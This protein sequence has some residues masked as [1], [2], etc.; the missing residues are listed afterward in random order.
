MK[1]IS[2]GD[3]QVL[4]ISFVLGAICSG[5]ISITILSKKMPEIVRIE[6][7]KDSIP[8]SDSII[9]ARLKCQ[10]KKRESFSDVVYSDEHG[11]RYCAYG[12]LIPPNELMNSSKWIKIDSPITEHQGDSILQSDIEQRYWIIRS[13]ERK[14]LHDKLFQLFTTGIVYVR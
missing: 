12:H 1:K 8:K 4:L 5:I 11:H 14:H 3:L 10:L 6:V 9:M 7:R 13:M 2:R